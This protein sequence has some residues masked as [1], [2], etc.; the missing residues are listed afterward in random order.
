MSKA[1]QIAGFS[2]VE[3]L[4][5]IVIMGTVAKV[6]IPMFSS[7]SDEQKLDQAASDITQ[8]LRF[9]KTEALRQGAC[10]KVVVTPAPTNQVQVL[11]YT[12]CG[13]FTLTFAPMTDPLNKSPYIF[14]LG[15]GS[16]TEGVKI[17]AVSFTPAPTTPNQMYFYSDGSP[18]IY[19]FPNYVSMTNG[20]I[21]LSM[22][23]I[24]RT[25]N[26]NSAGRVN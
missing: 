4:I 24:T 26:I 23:S 1:K 3:L 25:L 7:V 20:A 16:Q 6:A 13:A 5:V 8:A 12:D 22:N 10:I 21:V 19:V 2:L 14:T 17:S 9:A 18:D 11:K 15:Q